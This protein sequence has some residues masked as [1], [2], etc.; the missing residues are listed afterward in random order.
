[1][2]KVEPRGWVNKHTHKEFDCQGTSDCQKRVS[3][4]IYCHGY[5]DECRGTNCNYVQ[6]HLVHQLLQGPQCARVGLCKIGADNDTITGPVGRLY[7]WKGW[8]TRTVVDASSTQAFTLPCLP[9]TTFALPSP[10]IEPLVLFWL[11][12]NPTGGF[13][14][15]PLNN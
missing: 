10:R 1:M 2:H 4:L 13:P 9:S 7:L 11:S 5:R 15:N 6:E 14:R 12:K 8:N 3:P